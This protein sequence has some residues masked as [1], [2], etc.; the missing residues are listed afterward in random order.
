LTPFL[1][2]FGDVVVSTTVE[3]ENLFT[4][5]AKIGGLIALLKLFFVF[6]SYHESGFERELAREHHKDMQ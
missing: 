4:A 3:P 2:H 1:I 5:L 6:R